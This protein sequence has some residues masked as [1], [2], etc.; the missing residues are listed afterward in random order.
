[1][2]ASVR[3]RLNDALA[4]ATKAE[5]AIASYMLSNLGEMPFETAATLAQKIGVSELTVGRFCRS[6]GYKRFK[7]LKTDLKADIGDRP[8]LIGDRLREFQRRSRSG[9]DEFAKG[10]ELEIAGLVKVYE[11]AHTREWQ[12]V[13][14][15]L[16]RKPRVYVAGFQTERGM[17]AIFAHQLQYLRDGVQLLD[18]AGGNFAELLL[19]DRRNSCLVMFEA[20]RYSRLAKLLAQKAHEAGIP[21]T[22]VTDPFCDWGRGVVGEIL[23]VPT[24]FNLFWDS[25][26]QMAS[27]VNLLVN[28]VFNELGP[29]IEKR[30]N[31]VS[32]LYSAFI[33]YVG[34]VSGPE[35]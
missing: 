16:A 25:T 23:I 31:D 5:T 33:G 35:K 15:R 14:K 32:A 3:Q 8:W 26:A 1:M 24:E 19:S 9:A 29:D 22:L 18:L 10:L 20:R 34:E 12:R 7:D 21:T 30:M 6:I 13:V 4:K 11:M 27:L 17:A 2:N 28:G